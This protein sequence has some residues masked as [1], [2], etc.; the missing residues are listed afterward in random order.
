VVQRQVLYLGEI[1][2]SQKASWLR[3]IEA[4]D[5]QAR[6]QVR[7]AL[8]PDDRPLP[9]H[10]TA[11]GVQVRLRGFSI[12]RSRQW[13]A[14]WLFLRLW[15]ELALSRF[16]RGAPAGQ[17]RGHFLVSCAGGALCVSAD[18]AGQRVATA[19]GMV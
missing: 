17:S 4:F 12:R 11:C 16:W 18:R 5:P 1:N 9:A 8:F 7:L 15:E 6:Q 13:G 14:C 3:C 2:D 19:S 10:A